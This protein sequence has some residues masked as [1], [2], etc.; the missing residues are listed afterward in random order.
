VQE[1]K[2]TQQTCTEHRIA[3]IHA[4]F[5]PRKKRLELVL[6]VMEVLD[7]QDWTHVLQS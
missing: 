3:E 5:E 1:Q 4:A 7:V 6:H 2:R